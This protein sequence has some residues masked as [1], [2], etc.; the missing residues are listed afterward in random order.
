MRASPPTRAASET[1]FGA[2]KVRSRPGRWRICPSLPRRPSSMPDPSRH[3][4]LQAPRGRRP[5]RPDPSA[6]ALP[7][8]CRP[9]RWRP[10]GPDRPSC[11][12]RRAR[13]RTRPGRRKPAHRSRACQNQSVVPGPSSG[14]A[15][16]SPAQPTSGRP[17]PISSAGLFFRRV[18]RIVC[19][20]VLRRR[21]VP[22]RCPGNSPASS[23]WR[24]R[25]R[26]GLFRLRRHPWG[27]GR[28]LRR[29]NPQCAGYLHW[30]LSL[31]NRR[32]QPLPHPVRRL[33][34]CLGAAEAPAR[35]AAAADRSLRRQ[36]PPFPRLH[37]R[38]GRARHC[39]F[40]GHR[41]ACRGVPP[42]PPPSPRNA[43]PLRR[44][45]RI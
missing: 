10:Y 25:H 20:L 26:R 18:Y 36:L 31:P 4:S 21:P 34:T 37:S 38:R 41:P 22:G 7:P 6:R 3:L 14:A 33:G 13:S 24:L 39:S 35:P 40:P 5:G 30:S 28:P 32:P 12:S 19:H 15:A 1:D 2:E 23:R 42:H 43:P 29:H 16:P 27:T 11:S 44:A 45:R 8:P 17:G 9:R